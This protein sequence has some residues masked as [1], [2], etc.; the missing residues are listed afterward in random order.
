VVGPSH[1]RLRSGGDKDEQ[2]RQAAA[3][4][5]DLFRAS[6][7]PEMMERLLEEHRRAVGPT[8]RVIRLVDAAGR[9]VQGAV[10]A[11]FRYG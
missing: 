10:I 9:P 11:C 1:P 7:S 6:R 2:V 4:Y 8:R 3:F 5:A